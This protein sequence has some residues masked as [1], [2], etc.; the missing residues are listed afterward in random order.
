MKIA[1]LL[2]EYGKVTKKQLQKKAFVKTAFVPNPDVMAQQQSQ[3]QPA[4]QQQQAQQQPAPQQQQQAAPPQA[5]PGQPVQAQSPQAQPGEGQSLMPQVM[6]ELQKLPQDVQQQLAPL[7][8]QLQ[9]MPAEQREPQL[10]QLLQQMQQIEQGQPPTAAQQ[11]QQGM[12]AQAGAEEDMLAAMQGGQP[13][14]T[15]QPGESVPQAPGAQDAEHVEASA[16]EAKNE[17]DNVRVSLTVRE[18]LDLTG[19][20]AA[21]ESF[22]KV[23]QL[24]DTHKQKMEQSKQKAD[25]AQQQADQQ[26]QAQQQGMMGGGGI[27]PAPMGSQ[28]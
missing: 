20:G 5:Q 23:K 21:T 28:Q 17:L 13:Q 3:Q 6:Q 25:Q 12:V 16:V 8:Q 27:Y 15:P 24:A 1:E 2:E 19:K 10:E 22:L 18:L 4:P 26:Q 14:G 9:A 11:P 7:L